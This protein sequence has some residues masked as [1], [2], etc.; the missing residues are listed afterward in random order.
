MFF[1][2]HSTTSIQKRCRDWL[3]WALNAL[4]A[5]ASTATIDTL[6]GLIGA[7]VTGQG[8]LFHNGEHILRLAE[9]DDP[10]STLAALFHD[11]VYVQVDWGL[12]PQT[13]AYLTP[14]LCWING[15]LCIRPAAELLQNPESA[16]TVLLFGLEHVEPLPAEKF[17]EFLSALLATQCLKGLLSARQLAELV[18]AIEASIPFRSTA[19]FVPS[20]QLFERLSLANER[21]GFAMTPEAIE[22]AIHRAVAF[23]NRDVGDFSIAD[24]VIFL[25]QTWRLLPE[26]TPALRHPEQYS[27]QDYRSALRSMEGFLQQLDAGQIFQQFRELPNPLTCQ[28]WWERA[29]HNLAIARLYLTSKVVAVA[30]LEAW[31]SRREQQLPLTDWFGPLDCPERWEERFAAAE[32]QVGEISVVERQVLQIAECGRT[33]PCHFDLVKSP[34]A[35]F[36]MRSLGFEQLVVLRSQAEAFFEQRL[37]SQQFLASV[38]YLEQALMR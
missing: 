29:S 16:C 25:D 33:R 8:R 34:F 18:V 7:T 13:Q 14:F 17:N 2:T 3:A 30:I 19:E 15:A 36:L 9:G 27:I 26:F 21:F 37:S 11:A 28:A 22:Q 38:P 4:D 6:N 1:A 5:E 31:A 32:R 12:A 35:A 10:I 24:P 20:E 23:A